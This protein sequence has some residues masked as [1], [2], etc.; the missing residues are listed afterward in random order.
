MS[1]NRL[2]LLTLMVMVTATIFLLGCGGNS[3]EQE[4]QRREAEDMVYAA[5]LDKDYPRH[6]TGGQFQAAGMFFRR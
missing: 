1:K 5:Y 4:R 6:R 3:G 2:H